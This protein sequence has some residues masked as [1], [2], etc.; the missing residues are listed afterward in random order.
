MKRHEADYDLIDPEIA[1]WRGD[2]WDRPAEAGRVEP[3]RRQSRLLKWGAYTVMCLALVAVLVAGATGWWY[4]DKINPE[5]EPGDPR[6]FIVDRGDSLETVS[7]RLE[8]RGWVTDA[9]VF[10]WYVSNHGGLEL[11]PGYYEIAPGDH[12]GNVLGRLRTPPSE[13]Y[14]RVTFPEGFTVEQVAARLAADGPRMTVRD[15]EKAAKNP[16]IIAALRPAG[17]TSL[18]GLLFPDTYQ[19]S[20]SE[21]EAQVIERMIVLMERV[22]LQEDIVSKSA[23][24]GRT[25]YETLI[26][27]SIIEEEALL[28][29]DRPKIARVIYN[30]LAMGMSLE[31]DATLLYQQDRSRPIAELQLIDTPYNTYLHTGLPPT[32]ITNPGRAS[33]EAALNPAPNPAPGDAICRDLPDPSDCPYLFYVLIDLDGRHAF[34]ATGEQH[35]ANIERAVDAGV[36]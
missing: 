26:V 7:E 34:A 1:D 4:I 30:R 35:A 11:T 3:L 29:E 16:E 20:N 22:G 10:R 33:I 2:P 12:M 13:T 19:V 6:Q 18:E 23:A 8:E 5:G 24:L 36:L 27:A 9:G 17:V 28:A 14:T 21:S 31:I 15:F 25:P 32:P